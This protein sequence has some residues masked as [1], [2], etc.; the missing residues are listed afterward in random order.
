MSAVPDAWFEAFAKRP[1]EQVATFEA[2]R[3]VLLGWGA[4]G[5]YPRGVVARSLLT[6]SHMPRW[7]VGVFRGRHGAPQAVQ[8][9]L[10][11]IELRPER[12]FYRQI[13]Q[14]LTSVML[15]GDQ[16]QAEL[17][18]SRVLGV[19]WSSDPQRDGSAEE[20]FASGLIE[21]ARQQG[22]LLAAANLLRVL[23]ALG[24]V[25]EVREAA[26]EAL[27]VRTVPPSGWAPAVGEVTV[28]R[29]WV[30]EDE[31]GDYATV[32][33]EFAYGSV[34][35]TTRHGVAVHV[36][37]VAQG[38]AVDVTLVDDVDSAELELRLGAEHASDEF[39]RVEPGW[40]GAVLEQAFAHT[41]LAPSTPVAPG[42]AS[43]RALALARVRSLP[44]S[45]LAVSN[46]PEASP[47]QRDAIVAEFCQ[48]L[49]LSSSLPSV[50]PSAVSW[51]AARLL[52]FAVRIDPRDLLRVSP[53]RAEA[54]LYD[55][56]PAAIRDH[57][58][59][60]APEVIG[61]VLRVWSAWSARQGGT[62]LLTRDSLARAVDEIVET[63]VA[64]ATVFAA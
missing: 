19:I 26:G 64:Q 52:D 35:S 55:W 11:D 13:V 18:V 53:G 23:A 46:G 63:Y 48:T 7:H 10:F 12:R 44:S 20:V 32:L 3:R 58:G 4:A 30:A 50:A 39:R 61:A 59:A 31:F 33:V 62:P 15:G 17:A 43:L 28:G 47:L 40:A 9:A 57:P 25:R 37:R 16:L 56:L 41:D 5:A 34:R 14:A 24:T 54:F 49:E 21:Y 38:A 2:V 60:P 22:G 6:R 45:P 1:A 51:V 8:D 36:D 27:T 29:C 42:F